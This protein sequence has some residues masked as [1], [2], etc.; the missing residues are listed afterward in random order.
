[1]KNTNLVNLMLRAWDI[2]RADGCTMA[3]ALRL[4][5]AEVKAATYAV[6]M[7]EK[8]ES[9]VSCLAKLVI[10]NIHDLHKADILRAA[11][12]ADVVDGVAMM[13]GKWAG[14]VSWACRNA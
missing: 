8:R 7:D 14:L 10:S 1:M 4:A 11:L 12:R 3:D 2:R 9:V 13:C 5:W 6:H